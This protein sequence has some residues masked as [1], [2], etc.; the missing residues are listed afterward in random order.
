MNRLA[1]PHYRISPYVIVALIFV[2]YMAAFFYLHD[3]AG[4]G[5]ASLSILPV[6][7]AS[8]YFGIK[9]GILVAFLST[10][11]NSYLLAAEGYR[12]DILVRNPGN[13]AGAF[14]L[15]VIA[16]VFGRLSTVT[17]DRQEILTKLEQFER[18]RELHTAFLEKLNGITAMALEADSLPA[19]LD[20][21]TEQ[22]ARL[23]AADDVFLSF[24]DNTLGVPI[25]YTAYGSMSDVYPHIRVEPGEATP[26]SSAMKAKHPLAIPN[27]HDS[28]YV[29]A[30][31]AA[32]FPSRSMLAIPLITQR[33]KL[34]A[35]ILGYS[36]ER[37]FNEKYISQ[38]KVVAEQLALVVSKSQLLEE[39]RKQLRR[40]KALH[41]VALTSIG[42][43]NEDELIERVTGIIG[44]NLFPDNFGILLLDENAGVLRPHPSYRF[45]N[46]TKM[47]LKE[48]ALGTGITGKVAL[49][50]QPQRIGN[51]R[52]TELYIEMDTST[53]S[54][55]CVPIKFKENILGVINAESTKQ[56][57]FTADDERLLVTLAGQLATAIEQLRRAQAER[58]W[59]DQLAHSNDLIY[60]IAQI[61]TQVERSLSP[62][63]IIREL[64]SELGKIGLTCILARYS[65]EMNSFT[66][67]YTSMEP[68]Q[69][70]IVENG[71]G[72][73]LI[74]YTFP[75]TKIASLLQTEDMLRPA[76]LEHPEEEINALFTRIN[77]A[78]V[79]ALLR[80]IGV[81][82]KIEPLRLPLAFEE[83]LLGMLWVWGE[84]ITRSDLPILSIFAK[85][86]GIS[87]ERAR[88]FQEV[89][90][91]A[92]TDP[93]TR[94]QNRRSVFELGRIEFSRA[95]RMERPFSC[96]MLDI[97]H[98]K[99]IND[100]YGHQTGDQ[101]LQE[102]ARRCRT[103]IREIDLV[104]RYGGEE[105]IILLP[106]TD[107]DAAVQV[108]ERFRLSTTELPFK[109]ADGELNVT[110]SIGVAMKDENTTH[111][112][113]LV[114]RADQALYIA[115]HKGRD[116]VAISV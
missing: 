22:I 90:N 78:G 25:P 111:L 13:L 28:P 21:L 73:P 80:A 24:W 103:S 36:E 93:L 86:V 82:E 30:A 64:G 20:I 85:Q 50:G 92:L 7:G 112:E 72:Y 66:I 51:V 75:R 99:K 54:E 91:L 79:A 2:L 4:I 53:L 14:S 65:D 71:L 29:S 23:F 8:W 39:E 17:R 6:I 43:D 10:L 15:F 107:R 83:N 37:S 69:L 48:L 104:G 33:H 113:A 89:Q 95:Q 3:W 44:N 70:A 101:V 5:V 32:T 55:L 34:G 88:L 81:S 47:D 42:A 12:M 94:L 1:Y 41:D 105:F 108:A 84:G 45:Y 96:M 59:L 74:N 115:K 87:L 63:E 46:T 102:F 61:T 58:K 60:S 27:V 106:E 11:A 56:D 116:R 67:S 98:F 110:V 97:D 77:P 100:T 109:V 52:F 49:T 57:A 9:G 19:T 35:I 62:E 76:I 31:L 16:I 114:A 26:A 38:A 18:E 68:K 40:L